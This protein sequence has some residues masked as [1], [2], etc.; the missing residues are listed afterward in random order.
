MTV[1]RQSLRDPRN[2][3][4]TKGSCHRSRI[5]RSDIPFLDKL[6]KTKKYHSSQNFVKEKLCIATWNTLSLVSDSS[7]LYQLSQSIDE[8]K[9]DF[10]GITETHMPNSGSELLDNG[11]LFIYSGRTDGY[12]RDGVGFTL[13]KRV[14]NSL[15]SYTP[16]SERIIT[17]R[18]HS[19][20]I[21]ITFVVAYAPTNSYS[22]HLKDEFYQQLN[23]TFSDLPRHD[24][25]ILLGDFNA[26]L[27]TDYHLWPG[28]IGKHSLHGSSND[29]GTR[30]LDFCTLNQLT[31]GGTL[32]E[33][34]DIHKGTWRSPDGRTVNQIDHICISTQWNHSLLDVKTC[35]GADI[36]SDHYLVR[37]FLRIK[38]K[39]VESRKTNTVRGPAL[40]KLRDKS[41][42]DEYNQ[43]LISKFTDNPI[44]D[45]TVDGVWNTFKNNVS[46]VALDVL[47]N[48]PKVRKEEHLTDATRHLLKE[49]SLVKKEQPSGDNRRKYSR[50]NKLVK[51][52]CKSDE[53]RWANRIADDLENAAKLGKQREVWQQI[54]VLS[55][56]ANKKSAAVRD[57]SGKL[58][59][60]PVSQRSRWAEYFG[61]LLNP[62]QDDVDLADLDSEPGYSYFDNLSDLDIAP[63]M[64]EIL[65]A[66]TRLKN[67]KSPGVDGISNEELKYGA[68]ALSYQLKVIFDKVWSG[69]VIPEDW[70]KGIIA[71]I[72]KKGDTSYCSN[73]RGITLRSTA[74]KVYQIIM[75]QRLYDGLE[76]LFRENQCGFRRNRSCVDQLHS[77]RIIIQN[78][79]EY[80]VPLY[81]NF[82]DFKAAFDSINRDFVWK[83]FEHYGLP[84]KY[85]RIFK[86]FFVSTVSAVR[87]NGELSDWFD[88]KSGTGQ[89]DIQG[90]P[91]FNVCL[92]WVMELV[93]LYKTSSYGML[94]EKAITPDTRDI[95]VVDLDYADDMATLDN[96][97]EGLQETT[98]LIVKFSAYS[99]LKINTKK[100]ESM[101]ISKQASQRP[102][103][104]KDLLEIKIGE[105]SVEQCSEFKYL[106]AVISSDNTLDNELTARIGKA[107]GAFNRLN[108][109]W[110]NRNITLPVK[111]RIYKAAVITVLTYGCEVWNTTHAQM[112]RLKVFEQQCLR[113]ILR[114]RW[115]HR[116][117]NTEVL[118]RANI[119]SVSDHITEA[120]LRWY[121]HVVRM[122]GDRLPK[123]LV[124]WVPQHGKRSRGRPRKSWKQTVTED[125]RNVTGI[126][127]ASHEHM[128]KMA[129]NRNRWKNIADVAG[130]S[131]GTVMDT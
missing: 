32:F 18:L 64:S 38:L 37:G 86:A 43:A 82:I 19:R 21:N 111:A 120:R 112:N 44:N 71:V 93:E 109:I 113:R 126:T 57:K 56:K 129:H 27:G 11:S 29:N 20:H 88:V 3:M 53:N 6:H 16:V 54:G 90:P 85:I 83:A 36:G 119:N 125:F 117:K 121:G 9:L 40:E 50:L 80:N 97:K 24:I 34:R 95:T 42:V 103:T 84:D 63:S 105:S 31:V 48:R 79:L 74:S 7:K 100:T 13:S 46:K 4:N 5:M 77:L 89:G 101:T 25:K 127:D 67:Y 58:L 123:Y 81:I 78:S 116:V 73:N 108:N 122:P 66:L 72:G 33:H 62:P 131:D 118:K 94:L 1:P 69:E 59:S 110:N 68:Q 41:L 92:N 70:S 12:K 61:E 107:Y 30:L 75:L 49:R 106:G 76:G 35:R 45:D 55:G 17:A 114:V 22:D 87:V 65:Y 52:S 10:L 14:K 15:I 128:K 99:G 115:Y 2:L 104:E 47:G 98:D 60:D 26:K 39:N 23:A 96:T 28:I 91:I 51:K 124:D 130:N 8:Y 102:Y